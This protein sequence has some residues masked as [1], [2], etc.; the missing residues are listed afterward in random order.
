M[1]M[2]AVAIVVPA[3]FLWR[4]RQASRSRNDIS[5]DGQWS[6]PPGASITNTGL[7][8][9]RSGVELFLLAEAAL[10]DGEGGDNA[11]KAL[12]Q[13]KAQIEV[14]PREKAVSAIRAELV[15]GRN[16]AT[17]LG[18]RI[19]PGGVLTE[20]SSLRVFLLDELA[21][22]DPAAAA[23]LARSILSGK[24]SAEEWA[25]AMRNLARVE[26]NGAARAFLDGKLRDMLTY[27]PWQRDPSS[28]FLEAFDV[29]VHLGGT[30]LMPMMTEFL[31]RR[32]D[33]ERAIAHAAFLTLDR[34]VINDPVAT[35]QSLA[36][37]PAAMSGREETRANFFARADVSEPKQRALVEDYLLTPGR[38]PAELRAFAGI[39]PNFNFMI[40]DNLLTRSPTLD[41]ATIA[42]RD[43]MALQTVEQW[44]AD[45]RF[46][47]QQAQLRAM[48]QRLEQ[49][50]SG[51][52]R[53]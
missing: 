19:A 25:V 27:E 45:P 7:Q 9:G 49:F 44:L 1:L 48:K 13:L 29:V 6:R 10:W 33:S 53:P 21:R 12:G 39:F 24:T 4:S 20:V 34:L 5:A 32:D 28:G 2:I 26:N 37:D 3:L 40:S 35:L 41:G 52:A 46:A 47:A 23:E 22:L 17:G 42:L 16:T 50:T 15:S 43:R 31:R 18:F 51:G 38:T 14:M 8:M 36:A 30:N 11:R